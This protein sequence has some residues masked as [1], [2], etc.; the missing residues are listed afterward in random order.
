MGKLSS[1]TPSLYLPKGVNKAS[2]RTG[3]ID[4]A[5]D[6]GISFSGYGLADGE[7]IVFYTAEE[8]AAVTDKKTKDC[9]YIVFFKSEGAKNETMLVLVKDANTGRQRWFNMNTCV[10]EARE[11]D[12]T[13]VDIDDFRK[14]MRSMNDHGERL[15]A[16]YGATLT[17]VG[18]LEAYTQKFGEDRMP[19]KGE[20]EEYK[21]VQIEC[22]Y[23]DDADDAE[24]AE[25]VEGE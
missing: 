22:T 12:G 2:V 20:F 14:E 21:F 25:V 10:R 8:M 16:L 1:K 13:R 4:H 9:E 7:S 23:A 17:G 24:V 11:A 6:C 5:K 19:I 3:S 18:V 15:R